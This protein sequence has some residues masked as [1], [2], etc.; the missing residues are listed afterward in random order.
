MQGIDITPQVLT[1]DTIIESGPHAGSP[2]E[3]VPVSWFDMMYNKITPKKFKTP[4]ELGLLNYMKDNQDEL[5]K[6]RQGRDG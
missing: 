1:D 4:W 3:L 5:D 6:E 2:L